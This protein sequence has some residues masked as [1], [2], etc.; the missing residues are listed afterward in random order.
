MKPL[1]F[2][3]IRQEPSQRFQQDIDFPVDHLDLVGK[4]PFRAL[5]VLKQCGFPLV[6]PAEPCLDVI[7]SLL[8]LYIRSDGQI[9]T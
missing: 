9:V 3:I 8:P 2:I 5:I 1:R 6:E 4:M 7:N